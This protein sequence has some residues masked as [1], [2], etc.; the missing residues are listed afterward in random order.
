MFRLHFLMIVRT[1]DFFDLSRMVNLCLPCPLSPC[2]FMT[3]ATYLN[4]Y[5]FFEA[6]VLALASLW[7][8]AGTLFFIGS[9]VSFLSTVAIM[10][11]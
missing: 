4:C 5:H 1:I 2:F 11:K 10:A 9:R 3:G 7:K 8:T 6:K